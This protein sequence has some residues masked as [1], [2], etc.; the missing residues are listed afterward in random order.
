M[1]EPIEPRETEV[2]IQKYVSGQLAPEEAAQLLGHLKA[3]PSLGAALLG[4]MEIDLLLRELTGAVGRDSQPVPSIISPLEPPDPRTEFPL[5]TT[6]VAL[7]RHSWSTA[8]AWVTGL[9]AALALVFSYWFWPD[10]DN[11]PRLGRGSAGVEVQRGEER[12]PATRRLHLQ[13]GDIIETG[14][15]QSAVVEF[16]REGTRLA[17]SGETRLGLSNLEKGKRFALHSGK[18]EATVA[19]QPAGEPLAVDTPQAEASVRGTKFS[20]S[21]RWEATWLKVSRGEVELHS[22]SADLSQPVMAGQFAVAT[23]NVELR[24][25]PI[26]RT[27]LRVP[28][29]VDP[30]VVSTGGDGNWEVDG[31]TVQQ[32]KISALPDP[33]RSGPFDQNPFSWFSRQIP[34][35]G[36][37]EVSLQARLD[38]VVQEP[39]PLGESQFG[40][41][42]ILGRKHFNF[43]CERDP[44]GKGVARLYSFV[45]EGSPRLEGGEADGRVRTPLSFQTGQTF[46]FKARLTRLTPGQIQLQARV[47]PRGK[48]EPADWQL[49]AIR[50]APATQ[51]L[52]ELSTRRCACTFS[53]MDVVLI[54]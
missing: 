26:G 22:K 32:S 49:D 7:R 54:E 38:A 24:A 39:G 11:L 31:D 13:P 34:V 45:V 1:D 40:L 20:L 28:V 44:A 14:P 33:K 29:P 35:A 25:H 46:Q 12:L 23:E 8:L 53:G 9:A 36:N 52:L 16:A 19:R 2:L 47:W 41:T 6:M 50:N 21:S 27:G 48:P 4:Q 3:R 17:L 15:G 18:L 30:R 37:I 43:I 51:P 5:P 10:K 42:L